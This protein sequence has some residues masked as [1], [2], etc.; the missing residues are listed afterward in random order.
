MVSTRSLRGSG[1]TSPAVPQQAVRG[2]P[3]AILLL[4]GAIHPLAGDMTSSL[5]ARVT[6]QPVGAIHPLEADTT[7][8]RAGGATRHPEGATRHPGGATRHLGGVMDHPPAVTPLATTM[9]TTHLTVEEVE[10]MRPDRVVTG[11]PVLR[12][13]PRVNPPGVAVPVGAAQ[14]AEGAEGVFPT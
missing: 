9:T 11:D 3:P 7:S 6:L 2:Q 1:Q 8:G 4:T 12:G 5:A 10:D 13:L 14:E